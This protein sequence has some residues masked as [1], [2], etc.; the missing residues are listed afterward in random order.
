MYMCVWVCGCVSVYKYE[1]CIYMPHMYNM[2]TLLY[3]HTHTQDA[4]VELALNKGEFKF[5]SFKFFDRDQ[6]GAIDI[7][8][9]SLALS[10]L[11]IKISRKEVEEMVT[12]FDVD[13]D[14]Q[15]SDDEW[16]AAVVQA[17]KKRARAQIQ[18]D[19]MRYWCKRVVICLFHRFI[20]FSL[21]VCLFIRFGGNVATDVGNVFVMGIRGFYNV[22]GMAFGLGMENMEGVRQ[23]EVLPLAR[24]CRSIQRDILEQVFFFLSF[25]PFL[26]FLASLI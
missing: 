25:S 2:C 19:V 3:T 20:Y 12:E 1:A 6:S 22:V 16:Q 4:V 26:F 9:F 5:P 21:F 24:Y 18:N 15:I 23:L 13:G 11:G 17:V 7:G 10:K 8:E 14:R